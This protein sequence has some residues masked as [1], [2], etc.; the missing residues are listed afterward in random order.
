MKS[1]AKSSDSASPLYADPA[2]FA[3]KL[4]DHDGQKA[5]LGKGASLEYSVTN[6]LCGHDKIA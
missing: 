6:W 3:N 5:G 4:D 2:G 1:S